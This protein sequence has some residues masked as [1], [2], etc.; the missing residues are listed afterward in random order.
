MG[1]TDKLFTPVRSR[2]RSPRP[3]FGS[4]C[5]GVVDD[6][7]KCSRN[8]FSQRLRNQL[9]LTKPGLDDLN[10][11]LSRVSFKTII[12]DVRFNA[13]LGSVGSSILFQNIPSNC[14]CISSSQYPDFDLLLD[15]SYPNSTVASVLIPIFPPLYQRSRIVYPAT[16]WDERAYNPE[17]CE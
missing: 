7:S 15:H 4:C 13:I 12:G 11:Y 5:C 17:Y 16:P 3:S 1:Y 14:P 6:I 10:F 2:N 9:P 8:L